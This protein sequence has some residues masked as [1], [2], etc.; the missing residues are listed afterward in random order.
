[1]VNY[2]LQKLGYSIIVLWGVVSVVFLL[3]N[4]VPG[5]P[6]RMVLG[7]RTDSASI[8]AVRADLGLNRSLGMQYVKYLNDLSPVSY[9][10]SVSGSYFYFDKERYNKI[11]TLVKWSQGKNMLVLKYPYLRRSYQDRRNVS[12]TIAETMPNTLVLAF[13]SIIFAS[14]VGIFW[15]VLC[16]LWKDSWFDR[17]SAVIS[18]LGMSVPTFFAA[19]IFGWIFAY[20]LG[21]YTGLN[22]T[23]NLF[24]IDDL[25]DHPHMELKNL[26]LPAFTLGIRPLAVIVQLTRN[27]LLEE[28]TQDYVR[29]ARAKGAST[30]RVVMK[31]ALR[32]ALNPVV[33]AISGWF[34]SMMAGVVFVE[35]IFG[36]KGL[37]Y[38][39]VS[40]LNQFDLPV[41]MGTVLTSS[42]IFVVTNFLVDIMYAW[43]DPRV[44]MA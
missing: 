25:G 14:I 10:Q 5:D 1:V 4:V 29:T 11:L 13:A 16:A 26:I 8:A 9:H 21:K 23:G 7:Q 3:F 2:L 44:R 33:T 41:V 32:G 40:A 24:V 39:M 28:L 27:S 18:S 31:H 20:L 15:G 36:W 37:G 30:T 38:V 6:T 34:A 43:L 22:L 17:L 19:I 35:Y 42:V 12:E